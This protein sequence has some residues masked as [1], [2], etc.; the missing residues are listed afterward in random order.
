[1]GVFVKF[2]LFAGINRKNQIKQAEYEVEAAKN[3]IEFENEQIRQAVIVLYHDLLLKQ[4]LLLIKSRSLG[5][6]T[7]NMQM[8]EKEFRN[9]VVPISEYA[10]IQGIATSMEEEYEVAMSDFII[11]KQRLEE[12]AGFVFGLTNSM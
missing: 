5:D 4:K 1:M 7:V 10:R 11:A 6:A 8:V 3:M 9:G 12:M 2:P